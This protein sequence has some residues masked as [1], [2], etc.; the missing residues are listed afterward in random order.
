MRTEVD[1][2]D[3]PVGET[4]DAA[5]RTLTH[6]SQDGVWVESRD[7]QTA[8]SRKSSSTMAAARCGRITPTRQGGGF[9]PDGSMPYLKRWAN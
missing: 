1:R 4:V 7:A 5:G 6:K 8:R 2:P 3:I 9:P